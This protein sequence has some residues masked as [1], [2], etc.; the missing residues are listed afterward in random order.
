MNRYRNTFRIRSARAPWWDY[1]RCGMYFITICTADREPF[2]CEIKNNKTILSP[3]GKIVEQEWHRSFDIRTELFCDAFIV[4]PNHIHAIVRIDKKYD[5]DPYGRT[6]D[7]RDQTVETRGRTVETHGRASLRQPKRQ[8]QRQPQQ[9][10]QSTKYGVAY[11]PPKSLSSFVA[12]FKSAATKKIN[13]YRNTPGRSVWQ[14][15]FHDH[16]IRNDGEFIRIKRYIDK[17]PHNWISDDL[18]E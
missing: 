5:A 13:Q 10:G 12:G 16:I 3:I 14:P 4:M 11:R 8:S 15:R 18:F 9:T 6:D 2:L 17:N 1:G 7:P